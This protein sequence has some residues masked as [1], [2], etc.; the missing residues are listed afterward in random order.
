MAKILIVD[1]EVEIAELLSDILVDAGFDTIIKNKAEDA[2]ECMSS[3][4]FDL[5][6]LDIML[7]GMSGME[8]CALIR[9][10]VNCPIIFISAKVQTVDKLVGFEIGA[11]DYITKPFVNAELVARVKANIRQ[12]N[13]LLNSDIYNKNIIKIGDI[14]INKDSY[15]VKKDDTII[16]LSTKEFDL[17]F[18][19]MN[20]AGIVLSKDQIYNAVW[21]SNYG[22]I[23]TVAVHIKNLRNKIDKNDEYIITVWGVGYKFVKVLS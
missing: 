23:G 6:I 3:N 12:N 18:Y 9:N 15:E 1:D 21:G 14:E 2:L 19:L 11:D 4:N 5:I 8:L 22:D 7:P 16:E 10:K 17:L 13:R 20:N